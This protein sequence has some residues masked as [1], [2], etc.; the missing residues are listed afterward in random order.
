[1]GGDLLI[2]VG[3]AFRLAFQ[4]A[5]KQRSGAV[6]ALPPA[7]ASGRGPLI[8]NA[9]CVTASAGSTFPRR[10]PGGP[11]AAERPNVFLYTSEGHRPRA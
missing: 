5:A 10:T 6:S 4:W 1:M 8:A 3:L 9:L 2:S 7:G 11:H